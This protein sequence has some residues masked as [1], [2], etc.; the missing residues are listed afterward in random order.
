MILKTVINVKIIKYVGDAYRCMPV[1]T[2]I[3]DL[4]IYE[5]PAY[6]QYFS[7]ERY[8]SNTLEDVFYLSN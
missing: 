2:T 8:F 5:T 6:L 1:S 7:Q 3:V 4:L